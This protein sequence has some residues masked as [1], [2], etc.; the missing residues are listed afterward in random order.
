MVQLTNVGPHRR[1]RVYCYND[2]ML[3]NEPKR[4]SSVGGL[5]HLH[6]LALEQIN[7][8]SKKA[9]LRNSVAQRTEASDELLTSFTAGS[10]KDSCSKPVG[11]RLSWSRFD[12]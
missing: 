9:D 7:L 5:H 10:G 1:P 11:A 4:S 8:Q 2:A 3:E 12:F 6:D